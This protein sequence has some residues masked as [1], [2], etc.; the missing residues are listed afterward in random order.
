[1]LE[2]EYHQKLL[3]YLEDLGFQVVKGCRRQAEVAVILLVGEAVE[4][5]L[6]VPNHLCLVVVAED[7]FLE[8][9]VEGRV[10]LSLEVEVVV[11]EPQEFQEVAEVQEQH[12]QGEEEAAEAYYPLVAVEVGHQE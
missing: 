3:V 1:M 8:E 10:M 9:V 2:V 5:H 11:V 4:V 12:L 7:P 6:V